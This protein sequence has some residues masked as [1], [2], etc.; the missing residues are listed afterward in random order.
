M[1]GFKDR[2]ERD[3][4]LDEFRSGKLIKKYFCSWKKFSF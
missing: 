3:E 2:G 1:G 4:R